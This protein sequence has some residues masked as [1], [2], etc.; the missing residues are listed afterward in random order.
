AGTAAILLQTGVPSPVSGALAA[1]GCV[2]T[3]VT[4]HVKRCPPGAAEASASASGGEAVDPI[5]T[6]TAGPVEGCI[7]TDVTLHVK[8]CPA[9]T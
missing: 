5:V 6:P 4:L 7:K 9:G 1:E 2:K 3:D 8:R